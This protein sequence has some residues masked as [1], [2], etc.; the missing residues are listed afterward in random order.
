MGNSDRR[1]DLVIRN[2][3]VVDGTGAPAHQ[4]DVVI[5]GDR[6]ISIEQ[7]FTGTA[8]REID[9]SGKVVTPGFVDVHTH[10][11]AQLAW[12][13]LPTSTCWHGIT[14]AVLG[15]C[16]VT[17]A[18]VEPG[19]HEFLAEMM[20]S[21]EDI[22]RQAILEGLPWDWTTYG[23]YLDWVDRIDKGINVGGLV[24]HCAL[25]VA[26]MGDRAMVESSGTPEE[27]ARMCEMAEE[28]LDA[29]A[30]GISTSRTL[31]HKVPDGRPVPGTWA[32]PDELLAF[33]D[34]L[35]RAGHGLFEGAMRL[36]ERDNEELTNTRAEVAIMGEISR[37][38]GRPVS[39]GL[40]QSDRRPDLYS[41]TIEFT[42]EEN[43]TGG[44]VRP[45]TT[46]RG[47]GIIF[48]LF[49][50]TPWD[51][52][53]SWRELRAMDRPERLA[54]LRDP[55]MRARLVAD[56]DAAKLM[57]SPDKMF[58]LPN[59]DARYDCKPEDSLATHAANRGVSPVE[60]FIE[61]NLENDGNVNLNV[62]ILNHQLSA[63]EEMLDDDLVTLGLADAGAHVGQIMDASQPTFLLT[64][65]VR[66]RQRW[67]LEEAVRRLT[68]DTA[69]LFGFTDRGVL[70]EG[71]FADVNV[72]DFENLSLPQ[73]EYVNDLPNG[74]GRYIQGSSGYDYT[75][76]NGEVFMDH[77][78]HT[79]TLAGRL[80]RSS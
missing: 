1:A 45:Q 16:G 24:G 75:I 23:D 68:S 39:Y 37:R 70:A 32:G 38:S 69:D 46:A 78:E 10:L 56:G 42:K 33:G 48:Q 34:V 71:K 65:W 79:G 15:N 18:P 30:L 59:G 67:T 54:A 77:G 57:F 7:G 6:I 61:L 27:I 62:P 60:A 40:V 52:S 31:G 28:A 63:V 80:I 29:G 20:E 25:R 51:R 17:F 4:A 26:A 73:P 5:K 21:V 53:E 11:D 41:K 3:T 13:P 36:G 43:A 55:E 2:G 44:T 49:N 66:E 14:S 74:A 35:G 50:R 12:D 19:Q 9:A 64:Y 22:P 8:D 47:I 76:V 58:I 72:I